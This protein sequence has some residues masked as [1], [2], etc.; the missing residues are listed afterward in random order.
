MPNFYNTIY[1]GDFCD[2]S[3]NDIIVEFKQRMLDSDVVPTPTDIIFAGENNA[4]VT[5]DY[6]DKGTIKGEPVN[7]AKCTVNIK[8]IG[9]FEL[10][11]LYTADEREWMVIVSGAFSFNGWLIP[12]SCKE[13]YA[14]KPYDVSVSATDAIGTLKDVPFLT[15]EGT[16]YSGFIKDIDVL[17]YALAKTGLS[18]PIRIGIN[19]FE[20]HMENDECPLSQCYIN[21]DAFYDTDANAFSCH[22]VIRSIAERWGAQLHQFG[23]VWQLVNTLEKSK[24]LV[25]CWDFDFNGDY[26]GTSV[27]GNTVNAGGISEEIQPVGDVSFAKALASST[28][29]YRYGY[30]SNQLFN[31]NMDIWDTPLAL[32]NGWQVFDGAVAEGM[33]RLDA[34]GNPTSDHYIRIISSGSNGRLANTNS[35]S[36]KAGETTTISFDLL[37]P[38]AFAPILEKRYLGVL[39]WDGATSFYNAKDGWTTAGSYYVIEYN[40]SVFNSQVNVNFKVGARGGDYDMFYAVQSV[41]SGGSGFDYPTSINNVN[42]SSSVTA[43]QTKPPVG[44]FN[45]QKSLTAQTFTKDPILLLHSDDPNDKRTSQISIGS[46]DTVVVSEKWQ[47]DGFTESESLL[48]IVANSEIIMHARPYRIFEATFKGMGY[49]DINTLLTV[50]FLPDE[51]IFL[52]GSFD[53]KKSERTLTFAQVLTEQIE[54]TEESREDYGTEKGKDGISVGSPSG[55]NAPSSGGA[56]FDLQGYAKIS[57]IPVKASAIETESGINDSKFITPF[58]LLGWWTNIKTIA[59]TISGIWDFT[60]RPTFNGDGLATL[61]D[62]SYENFIFSTDVNPTVGGFYTF[63]GNATPSNKIFTLPVVAGNT[64]KR[65]LI[66]NQGTAMMVVKTNTGSAEI[67]NTGVLTDMITVNVGEIAVLYNNSIAWFRQL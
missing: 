53:L 45:R 12:D 36:I 58:K 20:E 60:S 7:G 67:Y 44:V 57:D 16:K 10:S 6:A 25:N 2:K 65:F 3:G 9:D 40:A 15:S 34:D 66:M 55:V 50:E 64:R 28:A 35:V 8:A 43:D 62:I 48:H 49:I 56:S 13:P 27:L 26:I 18:L 29:Y 38:T 42:I 37:A 30:P 19:T 32:P 17:R 22:E 46:A 47:R 54:Y 59:Q 24:G 52:S 11:S 21:T 51:Y 31:G 61:S 41:Q 63:T 39:I 1:R 14:S 33:T 4:P 5:V 23:G